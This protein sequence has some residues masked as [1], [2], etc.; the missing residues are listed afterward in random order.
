MANG[1]ATGAGRLAATAL[2]VFGF[3][4]AAA[5]ARAQATDAASPAAVA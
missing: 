1:F 3:M 4:H 2:L 5:T